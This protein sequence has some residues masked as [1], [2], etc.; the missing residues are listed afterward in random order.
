MSVLRVVF[1]TQYFPPEI[2]AA[3]TRAAHFARALHRAGHHV[4]VVTGLPNHP[5]GILNRSARVGVSGWEGIELRRTWLYATPKKTPWTRLWNHLSFALSAFPAAWRSGPADVVL[6]TTPPLF[7]GLT[8][9][10]LAWLRRAPL[11]ID[12]RDDWPQA[13]LAVGEMRPG[14]SSAL[15]DAF[16]KSLYFASARVVVANPGMA[17][18]LPGRGV[19]QGR[20]VLITNGA[21]TEVFRPSPPPERSNGE[22]K[23]VLYSGTHGLIH[24]MDTLL[25]AAELLRDRADLR[26][27]LVGDGVVKPALQ[28]RAR[29]RG[30]VNLEFHASLPPEQLAETVRQADL[31]VA[32]MRDHPFCENVI[33]VKVFD[34]LACGRPVVAATRGD[35]ADVVA[36]SGGGVVVEPGNAK[37]LASALVELV[38]DGAR[39]RALGQSGARYVDQHYSRRALG[40]R[41]VGVLEEVVDRARG[42]AVRPRPAGWYGVLKRAVDGAAAGAFLVLVSPFLLLI[43]LTVRASSPGPILFRQRRVGRGSREFVIFKFRTMR[44]GTPDVASHLMGAGSPQVTP[45][46]RWLRRTSLDELPQLWNVVRGEMSLVGPRPAL[47]NQD[48]LIALRQS[49]EIDALRPGVTGWAQTHGRDDIPLERKVQLDRYYLGRSSPWLD[50]AILLRTVGILFSSRGVF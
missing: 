50:V 12:C 17:R 30:L 9:R 38:Q 20:I 44:P 29:E 3:P 45:F 27:V 1:L 22:P 16:A 34:Y 25:E 15:L 49:L 39:R 19:D 2:G 4:T 41:L 13:A 28:A 14:I 37:A 24:G 26:F 43:A 48:D 46:G 18:A 23:R 40:E 42:R 36:S 33:P 8:A 21:D 47:F 10:V 6:V 31:C 35:T 11:V 5:G 32:T 7:I